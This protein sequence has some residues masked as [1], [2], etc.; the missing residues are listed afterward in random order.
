MQWITMFHLLLWVNV[1]WLKAKW[2]T[3]HFGSTCLC[4]W[5]YWSIQLVKC[6]RFFLFCLMIAAGFHFLV[7]MSFISLHEKNE[8]LM[9][10]CCSAGDVVCV[11]RESGLHSEGLTAKPWTCVAC[12]GL[13]V[14]ATNQAC[15]Q[16]QQLFSCSFH[17]ISWMD[18]GLILLVCDGPK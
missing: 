9:I 17:R 6:D 4:F 7:I 13:N 5:N 2:S 16:V 10:N 8:C 18:P 14:C 1:H 15:L 11:I 3:V 12:A